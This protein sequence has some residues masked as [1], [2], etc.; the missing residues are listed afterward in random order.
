MSKRLWEPPRLRVSAGNEEERR[1]T[2]LELFFD[3]IFVVAIAELA[4]YLDGHVGL[5][6]FLGFVALFVPIWWCWLGSTFYATRF[7]TDDLGHRLLTLLQISL[8][9]ALAVN[10]HHG[11]GESST[12]FAL[13]YAAFRTLLILQYLSA[14]YFVRAA[15]PL[16]NWYIRG[17]AI[18]AFL[19]VV[20]VWVPLPWRFGLWLVGLIVDFATPLTAG[21]LVTQFPPSL[22]HIAERLGLFTIIVLGESVVAVVKGVAQKEW[23]VSSVVAALLGLSIAFSLWWIYFDSVDGSPLR[24]VKGGKIRIAMTWLYAHLPLAIGLAA[25]GVGVDQIIASQA[26]VLSNEARWLFCGAVAL[27]LSVLALIHLI[28]C[29]LGTTRQRKILS[30]YRLGAAIFVLMLAAAGSGLSSLVLV[31]LVAFACVLQVVLDLLLPRKAKTLTEEVG[32]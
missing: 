27:C 26:G 7:D 5:S 20:S 13:S 30:A 17:F 22:S 8:V 1:A 31:A 21:R 11:L 12:G 6:G 16:I 3:L 19:W 32:G 15:R 28:T 25:T 14:G 9:A 2:W 4:H 10:V 18:S 23:D 24:S 29:T